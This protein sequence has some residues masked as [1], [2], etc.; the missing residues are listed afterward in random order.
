MKQGKD[1]IFFSLNINSS[2]TVSIKRSRRELSI[3]MSF[4]A[5]IFKYDWITLFPSFTFIPG[6]IFTVVS[7]A[8]VFKN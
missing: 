3:D 7:S 6:S 8:L 1:I 2:T 4:K 5:G